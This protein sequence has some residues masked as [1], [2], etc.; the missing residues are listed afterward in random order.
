[1]KSLAK[2]LF[3]SL[4]VVVVS[5][6][7]GGCQREPR[8]AHDDPR[9]AAAASVSIVE[10][11]Q[12]TAAQQQ[13]LL[14]AKDALF[15]QLSARLQQALGEQGPAA[16]IAVCQREAPR[17]ASEV[18]AS[19]GVQIGRVGV[20]L[21]N[22]ENQPPH[23]ARPLTEQRQEVATFVTLS[24]GDAAALLP[25]KLQGQCLMCHGPRE[26]IPPIIQTQLARLYPDDQAT[27]FR[28]GELRGWFWVQQKP[29]G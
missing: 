20:R 1:M 28:E 6:A 24:N 27:G 3:G 12:P 4:T 8:A 11:M 19:H 2:N 15:Q 17:L 29:A 7:A 23:W 26:Q 9:A 5:V 21:R 14:A 13:T 16:A 22:P 18:G 10:G 25:I